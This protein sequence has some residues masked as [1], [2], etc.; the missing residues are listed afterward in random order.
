MY[1][2]SSFHV[3]NC[4]RR[5]RMAMTCLHGTLLALSLLLFL[6]MIVPIISRRAS[7]QYFIMALFLFL[8]CCYSILA[9][10]VYC[11]CRFLLRI[12]SIVTATLLLTIAF[13]FVMSFL[14][15]IACRFDQNVLYSV[16]ITKEDCLSSYKLNNSRRNATP[17][18]TANFMGGASE[19]SL[20]GSFQCTHRYRYTT[21]CTP[22][23]HFWVTMGEEDSP[24]VRVSMKPVAG[25]YTVCVMVVLLMTLWHTVDEVR[26]SRGMCVNCGHF[27][28]YIATACTLRRA[29]SG[30]GEEVKSDLNF[31]V[32]Q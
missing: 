8:I 24:G 15:N 26:F 25:V 3:V 32:N 21:P 30:N 10:I 19:D 18:S 17:S 14:S 1:G 31:F 4:R 12:L 7:I 16:N 20:D 22:L 11:H 9:L 5:W 13:M 6:L 29:G 28:G 2:Q 23:P 27:A